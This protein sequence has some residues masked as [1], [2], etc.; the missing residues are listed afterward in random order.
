MHI[1]IRNKSD[2]LDGVTRPTWAAAKAIMA[3]INF[4]KRLFEYDKEHMKDDVVKKVKKYIE[5]KDFVP[6]VSMV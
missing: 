6:A 5:H 4:I 3:D 2:Q 1:L